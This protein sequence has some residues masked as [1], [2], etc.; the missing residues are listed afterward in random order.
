MT[1]DDRALAVDARLLRRLLRDALVAMGGGGWLE[2][3]DDARERLPFFLGEV[4]SS[5]SASDLP[6]S[7]LAADIASTSAL[8][9]LLR[10][11]Y[12]ARGCG[13]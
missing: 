12:A 8:L 13:R 5:P 3:A 10:V 9:L 1:D 7:S 11:R 2:R 4:A 6:S